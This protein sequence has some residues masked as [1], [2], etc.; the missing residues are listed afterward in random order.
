M[1]LQDILDKILET[2]AQEVRDINLSLEAE[3]KELSKKIE[4]LETVEFADL[5]LRSKEVLKSVSI[6][7]DSMARR[8]N[9]RRLLE[10]KRGLIEK[11]L[12]IFLKSLDNADDELYTK[13]LD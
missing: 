3:K 1:A 4:K 5:D 7:T 6:K 11:S 10:A 8:E 13:I 12:D 2:A 9:K